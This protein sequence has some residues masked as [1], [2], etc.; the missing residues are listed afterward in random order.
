MALNQWPSRQHTNP[1]LNYQNWGDFH[2][3]SDTKALFSIDVLL[4]VKPG[5]EE[6][7]EHDVN[8]ATKAELPERIRINSYRIIH[9]LG[10]FHRSSRLEDEP[11]IM[12]RPYKTLVL[13]DEEIRQSVME[14]K[15]KAD[16]AS[17]EDPQPMP[18]IDDEDE[19]KLAQLK[20]LIRFMDTHLTARVNFL[21]S[22]E[23][24]S[25][26]F[27]D[28]WLLYKPGDLVVHRDVLQ[29]YQV[30]RIETKRWTVDIN[31]EIIVED[32]SI[33]IHCAHIDF[34]GQFLGPVPKKFVMKKWGELQRVA[35]LQLIPLKR[36]EAQNEQLRRDLIKR[37]HAFVQVA[38]IAPMNYSGH[39][40]DKDLQVNGTIV[41]D[42]EEALRDKDRFQDWRTTIENYAEAHALSA[43]CHER[44]DGEA[45]EYASKHGN[46]HHD[47]YVDARRHRKFIASQHTIDKYGDKIPSITILSRLL[48]Q[49]DPITEEEFS[50]MS[51]RVFG[52]T[53][54]TSEW[55]EFSIPIVLRVTS[56]LTSHVSAYWKV[57]LTCPLPH[58]WRTNQAPS[59]TI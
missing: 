23:C 41:V 25:I 22:L 8:P 4:K 58:H 19:V 54:D 52:Y 53:M 16:S 35:S 7:T 21:E 15:K 42:F 48:D 36:A 31:G 55:G 24:K 34:D 3:S 20:C 6:L 32:E 45:L 5:S 12:F 46:P 44:D 33:A 18:F 13:F 39:T 27:S 37:G 56:G 51:H 30:T 14:L 28:L 10:N 9:F 1:E 59:L 50:I 17:A 29:A 43:G 2:S 47:S 11:I 40:L 26:F 57:F 38:G 49:A